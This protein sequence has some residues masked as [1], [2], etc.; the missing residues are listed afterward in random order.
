M[1]QFM[2]NFKSTYASAHN[3][4]VEEHPGLVSS[5]TPANLPQPTGDLQYLAAE[6]SRILLFSLLH[7]KETNK[8]KQTNVSNTSLSK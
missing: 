7:H 1:K 5:S 8:R 6:V 3:K 2:S 4:S